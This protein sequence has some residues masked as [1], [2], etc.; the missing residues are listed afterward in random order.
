MFRG[1]LDALS[2]Q[3][4]QQEESLSPCRLVATEPLLRAKKVFQNERNRQLKDDCKQGFAIHASPPHACATST[5]NLFT[6]AITLDLDQFSDEF[7]MDTQALLSGV[8]MFNTAL[9]VYHLHAYEPASVGN[10]QDYLEQALELYSKATGLLLGLSSFQD[11]RLYM[12]LLNN[13]GHIYHELG[14][15]E[16]S[17]KYLEQLSAMCLMDESGS[18]CLF[19][20][21]DVRPEEKEQFLCNCMSLQASHGAAA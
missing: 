16:R 21:E 7:N 12:A 10:R 2:Q 5:R 19:G 8:I 4:Q 3:Q 17:R 15:F 6:K 13:V 11:Y 14:Q 1:A 20:A 9:V 18:T